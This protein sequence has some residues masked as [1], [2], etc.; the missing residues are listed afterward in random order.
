MKCAWWLLVVMMVK[1]SLAAGGPL[2][3]R[4]SRRHWS[5]VVDASHTLI[6]LSCVNSVNH[7]HTHTHRVNPHHEQLPCCSCLSLDVLHSYTAFTCVLIRLEEMIGCSQHRSKEGPDAYANT[8]TH[9]LACTHRHIYG[10][11]RTQSH[12]GQ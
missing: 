9:T 12:A 5:A 10:R 11:L 3:K 6:V 7:A 2:V 4:R 1:R 8:H